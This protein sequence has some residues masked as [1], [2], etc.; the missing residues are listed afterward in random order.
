MKLIARIGAV[1]TA[2]AIC[3][4]LGTPVRASSYVASDEHKVVDMVNATRASKGLQKLA[5]HEGLRKMARDQAD[6]MEAKGT[7]FHNLN[8]GGT[9]SGLGIDWLR[10]GE[11]VG[12]GPN[13]DLIEQAFLDS[14]EH[15]KNIIRPEYNSVGIGVVDGD[16][17]KRY[18]VQV[19]ANVKGAVAAAAPKPAAP[20]TKPAAPAAPVVAPKAATPAPAA[21]SAAPAAPAA[22]PKPKTADPNALTG[23]YVVPVELPLSDLGRYAAAGA[24]A[25]QSG[26]GHLIDILAFWS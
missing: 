16:D 2:A 19:F 18:V 15:Y 8:L 9:I 22:T 13:V 20:A 3:V 24:E 21:P 23:G 7:I 12:M 11:I 10:V 26:F 5:K 6:K 25:P 1:A 17:G 4:A 14:P